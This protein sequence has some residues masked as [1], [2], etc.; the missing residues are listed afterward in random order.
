[1]TIFVKTLNAKKTHLGKPMG[2]KYGKFRQKKVKPTK[3]WFQT[4]P[5]RKKYY[6][7]KG[8]PC[9]PEFACNK[10]KKKSERGN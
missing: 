8:Q 1:M 7:S 4:A 10:K 9:T 2:V 5:R 3:K 6:E